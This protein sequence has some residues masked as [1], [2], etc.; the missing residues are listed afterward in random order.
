MDKPGLRYKKGQWNL[1]TPGLYIHA[2]LLARRCQG[3]HTHLEV[4]GE[5]DIPDVPRTR[6]AQVYPTKLRKGWAVVVQAAYNGWDSPRVAAALHDLDEGEQRVAQ[7]ECHP[8]LQTKCGSLPESEFVDAVGLL[9]GLQTRCGSVGE[10][11]FR[12]GL[13]HIPPDE[14]S[15]GD[16]EE[17]GAGEV[18]E[19]MVESEDMVQEQAEEEVVGPAT[20]PTTEPEDDGTG[21]RPEPGMRDAL[22][23]KGT[24][25]RSRHLRTADAQGIPSR[26]TEDWWELLEAQHCLVR[27]HVVRRRNFFG[28]HHGE[29]INCPVADRQIRRDRRTWMYPV[30]DNINNPDGRLQ[31]HSRVFLDDWRSELDRLRNF[32]EAVEGEYAEWT[33]TT[34]FYLFDLDIDLSGN[35][36]QIDCEEEDHWPEDSWG[37]SR[38][39]LTNFVRRHHPENVLVDFPLKGPYKETEEILERLGYTCSMIQ[40]RTTDYG[41]PVAKKKE[42][43]IAWDAGVEREP[44]SEVPQSA[45]EACSIYKTLEAAGEV[46]PPRWLDESVEI[47]LNA[48][49][50]TTG[51]RCFHGRLDTLWWITTS[52]DL[53]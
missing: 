29:W 5:S 1:V 50:S 44:P 35:N 26:Q 4:K 18:E 31:L 41:D 32:P 30:I 17:A 45:G 51:G 43:L 39:M 53:L 42:I 52:G 47:R 48:K 15:D 14:A 49:I 28:N 19:Y 34:T 7:D 2:L 27:H 12:E 11:E 16:G 21:M 36:D 25:Q 46:A 8:P 3:N 20:D 22:E 9:Q 23:P 10:S 33:G 6:Q 40:C 24:L 13:H 38:T 37:G